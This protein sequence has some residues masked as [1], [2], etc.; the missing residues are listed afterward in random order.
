MTQLFSNAA[1][2]ELAGGITASDTV[3][4]I[5]AGGALFPVANT[6]AADIAPEKDWFKLVLQD[7]DGIEIVF[8]RTHS[9]GSMTFADV[10]RGQEATT[11]RPFAVGTTV[12]LRATAADAAAS[13]VLSE[14]LTPLIAL[15]YA[16]L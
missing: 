11:A 9:G 16:G 3:M 12:G 10:L 5:A 15:I 6:G 4:A 13:V 1:R 14:A 7:N 8:V 2:G